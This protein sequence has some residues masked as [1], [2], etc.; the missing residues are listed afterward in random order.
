MRSGVSWA[1]PSRVYGER[2]RTLSGVHLSLVGRVRIGSLATM[3]QYR[4]M[5]KV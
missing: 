4:D 1:V 3:T 5:V 2:V